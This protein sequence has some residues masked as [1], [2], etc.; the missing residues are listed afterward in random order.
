MHIR[1]ASEADVLALADLFQQTVLRRGAEHYTPEQVRAWA[2]FGTDLQ[3]FRPFIL[4]ATTFVAVDSTDATKILGFAGIAEDGHVTSSYVRHNCIHQ[5]VGSAMMQTLLSYAQ[6]HD[7]QRLYAEAS[8][9]SLGLFKKFG[10]QLYDIEIVE[11]HG[12]SFE[13]YLVERIHGL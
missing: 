11:R 10:F 1:L 8:L 2:A 9:F 4:D 5:G 7:M 6:N 12:V 3:K 13:R